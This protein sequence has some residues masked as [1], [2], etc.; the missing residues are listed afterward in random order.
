MFNKGKQKYI[1]EDCRAT[2]CTARVSYCARENTN[3][4]LKIAVQH[5]PVVAHTNFH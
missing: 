4:F 3:A 5:E 1:V 2:D